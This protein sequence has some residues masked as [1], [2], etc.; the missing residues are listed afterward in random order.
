MVVVLLF[1]WSPILRQAGEIAL[2]A[3]PLITIWI[4]R[5]IANRAKQLSTDVETRSNETLPLKAVD[6]SEL[7]CAET[8]TDDPALK[9]IEESFSISDA[10]PFISRHFVLS[11]FTHSDTASRHRIQNTPDSG[12][13]AAIEA[14]AK[15][16]MDA[17]KDRFP[18]LRISSGF[19]SAKVNSLVGGKPNSQH[20]KGEACDFTVPGK[21]LK[22]V[23]RWI[24]RESGLD[25]DQVI[26]EYD[27]WIHISYT[28]RRENRRQALSIG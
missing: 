23:Y 11:D 17:I 7:V 4:K 24:V 21:A 22:D 25:F 16:V 14:L 3:L 10:E 2:A 9:R 15:G 28:T 13:E 27:R 5:L 18:N 1:D 19:R 20:L 8:P 6:E 26:I 12:Q